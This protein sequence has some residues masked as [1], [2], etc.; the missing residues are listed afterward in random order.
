VFLL[1]IVECWCDIKVSV[2]E[3]G[4]YNISI[5]NNLWLRSYCTA[6]Y[7]DNKWYSSDNNS[8]PLTSISTAQGNDPNLGSW[9]ET[10]LNFDLV[11]SGT[12]TKVVGSIRQWH[13]ISAITFNLDTGNQVLTNTVPLDSNNVRTVFPSFHIEQIDRK[14]ERGFFTFAGKIIF[15][16]YFVF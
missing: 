11:R 9:N 1:L 14:E 2:D 6:L 8:L 12:H 16:A 5:D 4:G 13:E 10:Q 15:H 3:K 7:A